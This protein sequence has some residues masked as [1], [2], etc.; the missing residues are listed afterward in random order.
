MS[1]NIEQITDGIDDQIAG[2]NVQIQEAT[3]EI[4]RLQVLIPTLQADLNVLNEM[5]AHIAELSSN[6]VNINVNVNGNSVGTASVPVNYS[7]NI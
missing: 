5:K 7:P 1:R 6:S 2:I 4:T 3:D